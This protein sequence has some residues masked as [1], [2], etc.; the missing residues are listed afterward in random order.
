MSDGLTG[1]AAQVH[2]LALDGTTLF[3][4]TGHGVWKLTVEIP[5]VFNSYLPAVSR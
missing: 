3:A 4:G 2:A 5:P 1:W